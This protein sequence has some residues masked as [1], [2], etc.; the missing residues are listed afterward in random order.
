MQYTCMR[1]KEP[2]LIIV[3]KPL[4]ESHTMEPWLKSNW[5]HE[6]EILF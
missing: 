5:L 3:I 6:E 4:S 1:S 2:G